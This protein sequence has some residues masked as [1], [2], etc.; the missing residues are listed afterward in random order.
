[1][2]FNLL[3]D[4]EYKRLLTIFMCNIEITPNSE[5]FTSGNYLKPYSD[6]KSLQAQKP[7]KFFSYPAHCIN[8][9][10]KILLDFN[11]TLKMIAGYFNPLVSPYI[12]C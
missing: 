4:E 7:H 12:F 11:I 5:L 8:Q 2:D 6:K 1:M 10:I 3:N 9:D